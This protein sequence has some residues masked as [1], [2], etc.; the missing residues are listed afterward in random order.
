MAQVTA[1]KSLPGHST[2]P[3]QL[4]L[5]GK[6]QSDQFAAHP[7]IFPVLHWLEWG[8]VTATA[9]EERKPL[10]PTSTP[11]SHV[12]THTTVAPPPNGPCVIVR[13]VH[14]MAMAHN[15]PQ[16]SQATFHI[17]GTPPSQRSGMKVHGPSDQW[18]SSIDRARLHCEIFR[19]CGVVCGVR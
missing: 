14:I 3:R 19:W 5:Q 4:E 11:P 10:S 8:D 12:N 7:P 16:I 9:I 17:L 18:R 15:S 6:L 2:P 1:L 13:T